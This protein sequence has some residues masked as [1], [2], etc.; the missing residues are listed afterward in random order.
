M[1]IT[2]GYVHKRSSCSFY[3]DVTAGMGLQLQ[4][5]T[6]QHRFYQSAAFRPQISVCWFKK[7][8]TTGTHFQLIYWYNTVACYIA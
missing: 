7:T 4:F 2:E 1:E 8:L 3:N 6:T 5:V